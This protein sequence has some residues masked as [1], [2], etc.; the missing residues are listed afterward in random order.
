MTDSN[1]RASNVAM[2]QI[3]G[4]MTS[5]MHNTDGQYIHLGFTPPPSPSEHHIWGTQSQ[6]P[7]NPY[8]QYNMHN[9]E[10]HA[11]YSLN[12]QMPQYNQ[13]TVPPFNYVQPPNVYGTDP[14]E[15]SPDSSN[16]VMF[17][18]QNVQNKNMQD[19]SGLY[20][21]DYR[22]FVSQ[23][24]HNLNHSDN[25]FVHNH[26]TNSPQTIPNPT[27]LIENVVGNWVPNTSGTYSPFGNTQSSKPGIGNIFEMQP[28]NDNFG[29]AIYED[30]KPHIL[31]ESPSKNEE[32]LGFHFNRDTKKPRMVA[33]VKPMRPSYSDVLT[34]SAPQVKTGK[35]DLKESKQKKENNKKISKNEKGQKANNSHR[36][37][38]SD[39]KIDKNNVSNTKSNEKTTKNGKSNQLNRK[40]AS[41][42]NVNGS[43]SDLNEDDTRRNKKT[44]ESNFNIK[45]SSKINQQKSGKRSTDFDDTDSG[46]NKNDTLNITKTSIRKGNKLNIKQKNPDGFGSSDKPPPG[47]RSQRIRKR[48]NHVP[49]GG[50]L[51]I[52]LLF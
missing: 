10:P 15:K 1:R 4:N 32:L 43:G 11:I 23:D 35:S 18:N 17:Q 29:N 34:K 27:Q 6:L 21:P 22:F 8:V 3:I 7:K 39:V 30:A 14:Y 36:L 38:N 44:E 5:G 24:I 12:Q 52:K 13:Q 37:N 51:L 47:K 2:E 9:S 41:L 20:Q 45:S 33:E 31:Q 42:D 19:L 26:L 16:Y 49:F 46:S 28:E 40:W 25:N 50:F 48:E